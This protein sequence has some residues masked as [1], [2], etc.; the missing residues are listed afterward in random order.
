MANQTQGTNK[1]SCLFYC[2]AN[3]GCGNIQLLAINTPNVGLFFTGNVNANASG[4]SGIEETQLNISCNSQY[5]C[6]G[7]TFEGSDYNSVMVGCTGYLSCQLGKFRIYNFDN[8]TTFLS[9]LYGMFE[10]S[11]LLHS[12]SAVVV[13]HDYTKYIWE[14]T[15]E[16]SYW[17]FEQIATIDIF[18]FTGL[19]VDELTITC[20]NELLS[21]GNGNCLGVL[22]DINVDTNLNLQCSGASSCLN[23]KIYYNADIDMPILGSCYVYCTVDTQHPYYPSCQNMTIT[24]EDNPIGYDF[25]ELSC[26][27]AQG[28][29]AC[30]NIVVQCGD[31]STMCQCPVLYDPAS[32]QWNCEGKCGTSY[33]EED[34]YYSGVSTAVIVAVFVSSCG[35]IAA[36]NVMAYLFKRRKKDRL[37]PSSAPNTPTTA[38]TT[39]TTNTTDTTAKVK[40]VSPKDI[41]YVHKTY[42]SL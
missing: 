26:E 5:S 1:L 25:I 10:T 21:E 37:L 27:I 24:V 30:K 38:N 35:L 17:T 7:A 29:Q 32:S 13:D 14:E 6:K 41:Q 42:Q 39:N 34:D 23:T 11:V 4:L 28:Y 16:N 3:Y 15:F 36:L 2:S 22:F 31:S 8:S 18:L 20:G 9:A 33:C 19:D 40:P 12:G